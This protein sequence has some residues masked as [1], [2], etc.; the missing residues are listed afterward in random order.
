[1]IGARTLEGSRTGSEKLFPNDPRYAESVRKAF[2]K[3]VVGT[4]DYIRL[5]GTAEQVVEAVQD[6]VQANLRVVARSGGH[7][8]ESFVTDPAVRVVIDTSLMTSVHYDA[9]KRAFA[10][11]PGVTLGEAY[12]KLFLGWG[13]VLPAGESPDIGVGG[14]VL[15]GAFGFLCRK[16]GLAG[17]HLYAVEVVVVDET[18]TAK[19]VV[20]TREPSDPHHDLWW[21]HTG[22]GGGNFGIVTRYWF[23]SPDADGDDPGQLLPAAPRSVLTF[24]AE[25]SW[26][27]VGEEAFSK[28]VRNYGEWSERHSAAESPHA[29]LFSVFSL[30]RPHQGKI[31]LRGVVFDEDDAERQANAYIAAINEGVGAEPARETAPSSWLAFARNPFPDLFAIGPGGVSASTTTFKIKDALLRRRHTDRQIG[32]MYH[33]LARVDPDVGGSVG[34]ATYGGKVNTLAPE[35]TATAQRQAIL[36]T[37]YSAG[38]MNPAD[39]AKSLAWLRAFYHDLFADS[40]G[41]PAPNDNNE[42]A[43]INHPDADLAD[44][45]WNTSGVP[46]HTIYYKDNY[47]RLQTVKRR[48]DPTNVFHHALSI[49]LPE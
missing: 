37:A 25:W 26:T 16:H 2:N 40:G 42:G 8:L 23:R 4:P 13:V 36:D 1:M 15:G 44:P 47:A 14:H 19:V 29:G 49:R 11:E 21:A 30:D 22:G 46:W 9:P 32:I 10:I 48:Y 3:R 35:A 45:A 33:Y 18:G 31:T 24:R 20:A 28:L 5:V 43:L 27:D 12:R 34:L 6:A 17:D 38:W 7:C 41:V 39:D